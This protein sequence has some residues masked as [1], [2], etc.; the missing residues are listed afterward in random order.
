M[1]F[2]NTHVLFFICSAMVSAT[3][4]EDIPAPSEF[5][6][7]QAFIERS[8]ADGRA[9]SVAVA[10]VKDDKLI[11]TQ[12]FGFADLEAKRPATADSVYLLASVSKPI[13][14]T[15]LMRLVDQGKIDLDK[16]VNFYL[17][18]A[19]LRSDRG[20][21]DE[22][23]IRRLANHTSGI[24]V[25]YNFYYDDVPPLSHD[26]VIRRYGIAH[27]RPGSGVEYCNLAFGIIDYITE[28]ASGVPWRD[29]MERNVYDPIGMSHTSD[30]VRPGLEA[31]ATAQYQQDLSGRFIRVAPYRFDHNGASAIWSSAI[32]LSRFLRLHLNGGVIDG[33]RLLREETERSMLKVTSVPDADKPEFGYGIAWSIQSYLGQGCFEHSGGMPGVSTR[34]RG[35]PKE[36]IGFVILVNASSGNLVGAIADRMTMALFPG[37][38]EE[39]KPDRRKSPPVAAKIDFTGDWK[40]SLAHFAGDI[41]MILKVADDGSATVKLGKRAE[42]K[43]KEVSSG[44]KFTGQ[45]SGLLETQSG[46]H[47]PVILEFVLEREG[48]SLAG[49]AVASAEGY[50]A[51]SHG[52]HLVKQK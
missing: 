29:F 33:K 37:P 2:S 28:I 27:T 46:Y 14:A 19:K 31:F 16:P 52:V 1:K 48:D 15:G 18:R 6:D 36:K 22:I 41:P 12:G 35:F 10:V 30:H 3:R 51:L 50:F 17:P 49:I 9:P 8:I 42:V 34:V 44:R 4:G 23:T 7:V 45:M 25:H 24:Q 11:W 32:D 38:R 26:E 39:T 21:A 5:N 40:G 13:T 47:G 20:S 43:L